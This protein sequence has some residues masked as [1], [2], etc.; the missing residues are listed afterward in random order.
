MDEVVLPDSP[1][2]ETTRTFVSADLGV[3]QRDSVRRHAST[4][5]SQGEQFGRPS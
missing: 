3:V 5:A 4:K 2:A 1:D